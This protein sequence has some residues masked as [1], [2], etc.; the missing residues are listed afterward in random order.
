MANCPKCSTVIRADF[1]MTNCPKCNSVVFVDMDGQGVIYEADPVLP[2]EPLDSIP[3]V[4][5]P[6]EESVAEL[7]QDVVFEELNSDL[8]EIN[9]PPP[10]EFSQPLEEFPPEEEVVVAPPENFN[11]DLYDDPPPPP[12][13][14][15]PVSFESA[16]GDL[17]EIQEFANSEVASD[18][19][20]HFRYALEIEN[21]DSAALRQQIVSALSDR[22]F[23]WD[24]GELQR[25]IKAGKLVIDNINA[26]KAAILV[27]RIKMLP[28]R[29]SW[30]QYAVTENAS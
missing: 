12:P 17:S 18:T 15:P 30:R 23:M 24:V 26:V 4:E 16:A 11:V 6:L 3:V 10:P 22:R 8:S 13:V 7:H 5:L 29:I 27:G 21:I 28:I 25:S 14:A 9:S 20:G 19:N 2:P 1:G